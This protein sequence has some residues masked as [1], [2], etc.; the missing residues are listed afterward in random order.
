MR[1]RFFLA[2]S[3]LKS[4]LYRLS[5]HRVFNSREGGWCSS[6]Y[7]SISVWSLAF[8]FEI[9][10]STMLRKRIPVFFNSFSI[11]S[12]P[13]RRQYTIAVIFSLYLKRRL[14]SWSV[15]KLR[16]LLLRCLLMELFMASC[17]ITRSFR[18]DKK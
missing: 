18:F 9:K 3:V 14:L 12:V 5:N 13:L 4:A 2:Y 17:Q 11:L 15:L 1:F 10:S 8:R 6:L 7:F 16:L